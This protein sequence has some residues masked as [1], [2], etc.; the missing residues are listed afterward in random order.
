M[1]SIKRTSKDE[2]PFPYKCTRCGN[3]RDC[4]D[5]GI[6]IN[7]T[8]FSKRSGAIL[9]CMSCFDEIVHVS[10][11]Y[12]RKDSIPVD[13]RDEEIGEYVERLRRARLVLN[14]LSGI[15]DDSSFV[16]SSSVDIPVLEDLGGDKNDGKRDAD[17]QG[18]LS[19]LDDIQLELDLK[20]SKGKHTK[21]NTK[22]S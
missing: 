15:L 14:D 1:P 2:L 13:N 17:L 4:M 6:N 10:G 11:D 7:E 20:E 19:G 16:T 8:R 18:I 22:S 9:L 12:I 5:L 3:Q 21:G